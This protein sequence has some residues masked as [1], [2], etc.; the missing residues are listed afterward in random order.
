MKVDPR[1]ACDNMNE[2]LG[3]AIVHDLIA[4]PLMALML[5]ARWS[6]QFHDYTSQKAWPR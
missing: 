4:H 6:V 5:Y 1:S 3:W 2:R